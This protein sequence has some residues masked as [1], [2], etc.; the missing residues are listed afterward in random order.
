MKNIRWGIIGCGEVTEVK[1]GPAFQKARGSELVAVMRR[2]AEK[3]ADYARRHRVRYWF[4]DADKLINHPEVDA[5]YIAT[6]PNEHKNY[7]LKC[8][9]SGNPVYVEKPMARSYPE[10]QTMINA[11]RTATVPLFVAYYR[12]ALPKFLKIKELV[13]SGAIGDIRL[14]TV[15][16]YH[17]PFPG[18]YDSENLPWRVI[19]EIAGAGRFLDLAS[20]TLDILDFILGPIEKAQGQA[21]NLAGLYPAEDT[22]SARFVFASGVHG[23]GSWCFTAAENTD[24]NTIIGSKGSIR[25]STFGNEIILNRNNQIEELQFERPPHVQQPLIQTIV[26]ELHGRGTC[27][28]TG[29]T[30]A[31]T[32]W[33]MDGILKDYRKHQGISFR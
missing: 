4:S 2:T 17:A 12:R 22:V 8:A 20:H 15:Q 16:L 13:T 10:C 19:P 27:P 28:S 24:R 9:A 3:A 25:F 7:T 18:D 23:V 30:A 21:S 31:R 11:C 5:V 6:P 1:S 26:D 14:V 29:E 33:V 32:S